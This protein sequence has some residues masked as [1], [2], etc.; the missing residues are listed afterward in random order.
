MADPKKISTSAKRP[1]SNK[2][3]ENW[4][5]QQID[6]AAGSEG[7]VGHDGSTPEQEDPFYQEA[8]EGLNKFDS[9]REIYQQASR[10]NRSIARKTGTDRKKNLMGTGQIFWLIVAVIV[11][12]MVV[13]LAFV[14]IRMRA[15]QI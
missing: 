9:A 2:D 5:K 6:A 1:V 4:L 12:I 15:G 14:V 11:V 7:A 13:I 8:M 3:L 10:V